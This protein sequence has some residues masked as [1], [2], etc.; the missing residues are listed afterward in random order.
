M[1]FLKDKQLL[2]V[3]DSC[4][5]MLEAVASLAESLLARASGLRLLATSREPLRAAEEVVRRARASSETFELTDADVPHVSEIC[6]RLDG[7]ALA[8]EL[9]AGGVWMRLG[10][11]A[12]PAASERHAQVLSGLAPWHADDP[13][14][15][16]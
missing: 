5:H 4:E 11:A 3:L 13:C 6:R 9:A 1:Q 2:I 16:H 10:S 15:S 12:S 7:N 14:Q 8:I